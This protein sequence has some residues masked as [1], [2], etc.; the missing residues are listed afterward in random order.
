MRIVPVLDVM[1]GVV[2]RGVGGRR[3]EY[4]PVVSRLTPS[5]SPLDVASAFRDVLGCTELYL[6]DLD[7]I[8]GSDPAWRLYEL[9][10]RAGC[11]LWVDAG[12][13]EATQAIAL[14]AAGVETVVIGLE[15]IRGPAALAHACANLGSR[16]IFSLD[17]KGGVPVGDCSAWGASDARAIA[18]QV[19]TLGVRRLLVLDLLRVGEG[20]GIGTEALCATLIADHPG[21]EVAAGGGVR[22]LADLFRL[23][24]CGVGAALVASALHDGTLRREDMGSLRPP[25]DRR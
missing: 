2:V 16:V 21:V 17:L 13:R 5:S 9:L 19:V 3:H 18:A 12:V 6:A 23:R 10:R 24:D 4:R 1:G 7:A 14:S 22:G 25:L 8:G 11:S 15:T 20:G